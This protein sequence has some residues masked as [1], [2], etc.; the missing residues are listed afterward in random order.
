MRRDGYGEN[1]CK[2]WDLQKIKVLNECNACFLPREKRFFTTCLHAR[3]DE[4][5]VVRDSVS[6]TR[7]KRHASKEEDEKREIESLPV[8]QE[9]PVER[10]ARNDDSTTRTTKRR[11]AKRLRNAAQHEGRRGWQPQEE[12]QRLQREEGKARLESRAPT[13]RFGRNQENLSREPPILGEEELKDL[14][15]TR[16]SDHGTTSLRSRSKPAT[17][18]TDNRVHGRE[19]ERRNAPVLETERS[20]ARR[21]RSVEEPQEEAHPHGA[22]GLVVSSKQKPRCRASTSAGVRENAS[23]HPNVDK[24]E[25]RLQ[26]LENADGGFAHMR[27]LKAVGARH[28][29]FKAWS[30]EKRRLQL[31]ESP[32]KAQ[33]REHLFHRCSRSQC[34]ATLKVYSHDG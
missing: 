10:K 7:K 21:R 12:P 2:S 27:H 20:G 30:H 17:G 28:A 34:P 1:V 32:S 18:H 26:E 14:E 4:D 23:F 8:K 6:R 15:V 31:C 19:K 29:P 16:D 11:E 22:G 3:R 13:A 5:E 9:V 33:N 24:G 25:T